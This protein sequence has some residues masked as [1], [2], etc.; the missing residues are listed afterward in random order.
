[1]VARRRESWQRKNLQLARKGKAVLSVIAVKGEG[2]GRAESGS[3]KERL[4]S[5]AVSDKKE[6]QM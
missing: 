3:R 4:V 2:Q 5:R 1:M 6:R